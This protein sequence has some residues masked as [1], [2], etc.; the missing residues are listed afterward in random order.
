[1]AQ[2]TPHHSLGFHQPI[3]GR[4]EKGIEP[5]QGVGGEVEAG[6]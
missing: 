3:E 2:W 4:A 5:G 6:V 1:M